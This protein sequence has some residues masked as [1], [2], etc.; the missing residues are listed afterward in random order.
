MSFYHERKSLPHRFRLVL[1]S[2]LQTGGLPFSDVLPEEEI[3]EAFDEQGV[4]FAQQ[5][6]EVYTPAMTRCP[7]RSACDRSK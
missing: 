6:D 3:Q 4:S 7:S 1:L 5:D 2:V